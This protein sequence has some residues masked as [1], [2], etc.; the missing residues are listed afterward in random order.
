MTRAQQD[1]DKDGNKL[2]VK[3]T[4]QGKK[5]KWCNHCKSWVYHNSD[6]CYAL[7]KSKQLHPPWHNNLMNPNGT[8]K[9]GKLRMIATGVQPA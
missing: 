2:E 8:K 4:R 7:E 6:K 9:G 5:K 3:P 1:L